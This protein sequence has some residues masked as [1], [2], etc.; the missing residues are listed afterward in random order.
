MSK[1]PKK[2]RVS[3]EEYFALQRE[4]EETKRKYGI[5]DEPKKEDWIY[6]AISTFFDRREAREKQLIRKKKYILPTHNIF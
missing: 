6:R 1:N 5:V 4:L 2:E 3:P